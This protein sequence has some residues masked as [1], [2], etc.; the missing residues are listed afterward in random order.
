[1]ILPGEADAIS[2][3]RRSDRR[4]PLVHLVGAAPVCCY[5][6]YPSCARGGG[7]CNSDVSLSPRPAGVR[8]GGHHRS[9]SQRRNHRVLLKVF[10]WET[11]LGTRRMVRPHR[12][13]PS[14]PV[15]HRTRIDIPRLMAKVGPYEVKRPI[16]G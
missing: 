2:V 1:M 13:R 6:T 4:R 16:R 7:A 14:L 15:L 3:G 5:V 10:A 9:I 11:L 12:F 8:P